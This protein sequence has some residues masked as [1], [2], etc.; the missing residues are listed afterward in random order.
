MI[1]FRTTKEERRALEKA[2]KESKTKLGSWCR[3]VALLAAA[4]KLRF[5]QKIFVDGKA[6]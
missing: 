6:A 1:A 4:N 5:V 3:E 2:A